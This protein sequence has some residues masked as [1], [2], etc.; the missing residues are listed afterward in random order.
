MGFIFIRNTGIFRKSSKVKD[1][2]YEF[3]WFYPRDGGSVLFFPPG[4]EKC[5]FHLLLLHLLHKLVALT[6]TIRVTVEYSTS[7]TSS[8]LIVTYRTLYDSSIRP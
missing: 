2:D 4:N 8:F 7:V 5:P 3:S 6:L 1:I